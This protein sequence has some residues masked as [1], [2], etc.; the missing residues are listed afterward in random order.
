MRRPH[1]IPV[2]VVGAG[3]NGLAMSWWLS[4]HGI[5]HVVLERGEIGNSW[6]HERWDSLRLLTPNWQN[7]LPGSFVTTGEDPAA[8]ATMPDTVRFLDRYAAFAGVPLHTGTPVDSVIADGD[9]Y[10]VNTPTAAW[11]CRALVI[12]TGAFHQP[13]L[14]PWA[15]AAPHS[16]AQFGALQY[17]GPGQLPAGGVLVVGA[18]ASGIQI[19]DELQ[20]SGRAVTLA[21]GEHVR[22]PRRYRG[23]DV[24]WWLDATGVLDET[25]DRIDDLVR[26]RHLASFQLV[27]DASREIVDLNALRAAGVRMAGRL[28]GLTGDGKA[29]FSGSLANVC[30]LADLK[31]KRLLD[32][33]DAWA[34]TRELE[35]DAPAGARPA[36]TVVDVRPPLALDLVR[37]GITS[38]IWATGLRPAYDWL[39]LRVFDDKGQLR[40]TGGVVDAPGVYTLGLPLLRRRRSSLIGGAGD[41]AQAL[42]A[43]LQRFLTRRDP[44]PTRTPAAPVLVARLRGH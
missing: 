37:E 38:I 5:G 41:D 40:H 9:G 7:R 15:A 35:I 31:L 16:I 44:V 12:A 4:R 36:A 29:Q 1:R 23:L 13:R 10:R 6:R 18:A 30:T 32:G 20:R 43:H 28:V 34:A 2:V 39:Q 33:F 3:Q 26:A 11:R 21:V 8:Y 22:V 24:Q 19:A 17:R 27:G 42:A 14:P 25:H